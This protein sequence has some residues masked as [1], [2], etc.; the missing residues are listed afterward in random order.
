M[1]GLT[2]FLVGSKL[3]PKHKCDVLS[4]IIYNNPLYKIIPLIR[5]SKSKHRCI[6]YME[7][8][9]VTL[10]SYYII[11]VIN[12]NILMLFLAY[13]EGFPSWLQCRKML[14]SKGSLEITDL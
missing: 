7:N 2:L 4:T 6:A 1:D 3:H 10:R 9:L 5:I 8:K 14:H 13:W 12:M 11:S